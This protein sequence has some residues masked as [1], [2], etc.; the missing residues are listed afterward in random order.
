MSFHS[1][2]ETPQQNS[3]VEKNTKIFS[4]SG[5]HVCQHKYALDFLDDTRLIGCKPSRIPMDP[6][7][8][9]SKDTGGDLVDVESK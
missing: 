3:V 2:L 8:N 7:V 9:L 5:I 1:S 4:I 6:S